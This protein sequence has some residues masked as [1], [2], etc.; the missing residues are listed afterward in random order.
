MTKRRKLR[1]VILA[2]LG[3]AV[4]VGSAFA[5]QQKGPRQG[6]K[7]HCREQAERLNPGRE[8]SNLIARNSLFRQCMQNRGQR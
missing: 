3:I 2:L 5:Q 7:K 4:S 1:L 6:H 8:T